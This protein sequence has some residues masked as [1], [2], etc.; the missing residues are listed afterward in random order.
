MERVAAGPLMRKKKKK[1]EG[2]GQVGVGGGWGIFERWEEE[3]DD[4]DGEGGMGWAGE[5]MG[6]VGVTFQKDR[7]R[8]NAAFCGGSCAA[9]DSN[10]STA[11]P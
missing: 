8:F 7:W 6:W 3:N 9:S 4:K 10:D 1:N 11:T 5:G 2:G